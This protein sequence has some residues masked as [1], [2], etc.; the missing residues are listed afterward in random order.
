MTQTS[1]HNT[2]AC[3]SFVQ[4]PPMASKK[5]MSSHQPPAAIPVVSMAG[6]RAQ[7]AG[8]YSGSLRAFP[9]AHR[10][11]VGSDIGTKYRGTRNT[12]WPSTAKDCP[13]SAGCSEVLPGTHRGQNLSCLS[14]PPT[15]MLHLKAQKHFLHNF[16]H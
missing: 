3:Q 4:K 7:L 1:V 8:K 12:R 5:P 16:M 15:Y 14:E 9:G 13:V 2:R 11:W 10:V 6:W